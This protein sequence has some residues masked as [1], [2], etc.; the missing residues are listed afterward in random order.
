MTIKYILCLLQ[1]LCVQAFDFPTEKRFVE[2]QGGF[3][4][5]AHA[6]IN[7]DCTRIAQTFR[8]G[9]APKLKVHSNVTVQ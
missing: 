6:S 7:G 1:F 5:A 2:A 4:V 9:E 8:Y 3:K